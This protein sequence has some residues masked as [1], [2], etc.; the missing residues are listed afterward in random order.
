VNRVTLCR[1]RGLIFTLSISKVLLILGFS[2]HGGIG[3]VLLTFDR[4]SLVMLLEGY[5]PELLLQIQEN[6]NGRDGNEE[7]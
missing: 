7:E 2:K 4:H 5:T 1:I 6:G 3:V